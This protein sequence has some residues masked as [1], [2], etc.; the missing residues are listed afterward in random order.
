MA[1]SFDFE[2]YHRLFNAMMSE[3]CGG[4]HSCHELALE[5]IGQMM[6][7]PRPLRV[8]DVGCGTGAF[9]EEAY[10]KF[11]DCSVVG[12]DRSGKNLLVAEKILAGTA[13][14]IKR[15]DIAQPGW[16]ESLAEEPFDAVFVG[17]VTHEI[18][19]WTLPSLYSGLAHALRDG[20]VLFNADSMSSLKESFQDLSIDYSRRRTTSE[21]R[22][23]DQEFS[24]NPDIRSQIHETPIHRTRWN[25]R[26][27]AETHI[28]LLAGAGFQDAEEIWRYLGH[29]L[30]MAIK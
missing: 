2:T 24:R 27:R 20:G 13:A 4:R 16:I 8:L 29:S 9:I 18:A 23:F 7:R 6:E 5:L 14:V 10:R 3:Y 28:R 21:F 12:V 11:G 22:I 17:W 15:A 30:I 19:P 1:E 25:V 26:H